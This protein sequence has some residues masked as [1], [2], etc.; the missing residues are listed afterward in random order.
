MATGLNAAH[1]QKR[2]DPG[3]RVR[4]R[5]L[6]A[7][8]FVATCLVVLCMHPNQIAFMPLGQVLQNIVLFLRVSFANLFGQTAPRVEGVA[9]YAECSIRFRDTILVLLAG[10]AVSV[11]G[12]VFQ[13]AMRNPMAGPTMLGVSSGVSLAQVVLVVQYSASVYAMSATRFIYCYAFAGLVLL[14]VFGLGKLIGSG[15]NLVRDMLLVG[16]VVN[17]LISTIVSYYRT[18]MDADQLLVLQNL[19]EKGYDVFNSFF[20]IAVFALVSVACILPLYLLRFSMNALTFDDED[21]RSLGVR[22]GVLRTVG[23][24]TGSV[25]ITA[26]MV[27]F[28]NVGMLSLV[29]PHLCRRF[30]GTEFWA[31]CRASLFFGAFFML[32]GRGVTNFLYLAN[33]QVPVG[34]VVNILMAILFAWTILGSRRGLPSNS[35]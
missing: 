1:T 4:F 8:V 33:Y 7:I 14:I 9:L 35:N 26:S 23:L 12:A 3:R 31:T 10:A 25:L 24:I 15:K 19:S 5:L 30:F 20:N 32:V 21:G 11:S 22:T 27:H 16:T 28:G 2:V 13:N 6:W 29:V 18:V 17:R 34:M